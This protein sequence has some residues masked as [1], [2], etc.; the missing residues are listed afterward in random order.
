MR[1]QKTLT[2]H[3]GGE[4]KIITYGDVHCGTLTNQLLPIR[5]TLNCVCE[6]ILDGRGF[7]F[8]QLN[9]DNFFKSLTRTTLSCEKLTINCVK[10][11]VTLIR[12][13]NPVCVI[14]S[15]E[16]TLSPHPFAASMTY[17]VRPAQENGVDSGVKP[18]NR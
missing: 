13:D 7:L 16:L 6:N 14:R 1:N 10:R 3:R 11:L 12:R 18:S 5:Y 17:S 4:F 9:I 8:E 2:L 15:I